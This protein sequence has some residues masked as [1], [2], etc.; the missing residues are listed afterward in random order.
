MTTV[1]CGIAGS[2]F[3]HDNFKT[4][5]DGLNSAWECQDHFDRGTDIAGSIDEFEFCVWHLNNDRKGFIRNDM[6]YDILPTG[7]VIAIKK[8]D[9]TSKDKANKAIKTVIQKIIDEDLKE[10]YEN[11]LKEQSKMINGLEDEVDALEVK[12]TDVAKNLDIENPAAAIADI[13]KITNAIDSLKEALELANDGITQANLDEIRDLL[14][15]ALEIKQETAKD[16][17]NEVLKLTVT[18]GIVQSEINKFFEANNVQN[19]EELQMLIDGLAA[20]RNDLNTRITAIKQDLA[21][22]GVTLSETA[23]DDLY[24][25][26]KQAGVESVDAD[27]IFAAG[28][29]FGKNS[30]DAEHNV[31][32][33]V[34]EDRTTVISAD[35]LES[36]YTI[37]EDGVITVQL[38]DRV[39]ALFEAART[40]ALANAPTEDDV[41]A[42]VLTGADTNPIYENIADN[43][44]GFYT[45]Y[46]K[47]AIAEVDGERIGAFKLKNLGGSGVDLEDYL[48]EAE[49]DEFASQLAKDAARAYTAGY[50]H[51]FDDGYKEGYVD[52]FKDGVNSVTQ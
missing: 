32:V 2:A 37:S 39:N 20:E 38:E 8:N 23:I 29:T 49:L 25:K 24:N 40:E 17:V 45:S 10:S 33:H 43:A 27:A 9:L 21:V 6:F 4:Q 46:T 15:P 11:Q 16:A 30:V 26:A 12:L 28:V 50:R 7:D 5:L 13:T 34:L 51:G 52:G 47:F 35:T 19:K 36:N 1:L 42:P 18:L 3:A 44:T 31:A 14:N 41:E 22:Y 48:T